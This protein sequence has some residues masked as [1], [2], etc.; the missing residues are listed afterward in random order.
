MKVGLILSGGGEV[1]I[2]WEMGV[3]AASEAKA[4]FLARTCEVIVGTSA[5][6][7][8]GAYVAVGRDLGELVELERAGKGIGSPVAAPVGQRSGESGPAVG[9]TAVVPSEIMA[10]ML[11]T[12]GTVEERG[13]AVGKLAMRAEVAIGP[14]EF[15]NLVKASLGTDAWPPVDFRPTSVNAESGE[16]VQ[17]DRHAGIDFASAVAS[18][19][20]IPGFFPPVPYNGLHYI[21]AQRSSSVRELVSAK[22]LDVV[23]FVGMKSSALANTNEAAELDALADQGL[24]VVKIIGGP[25]IAEVS[26]EL[27]DP[28]ARL[29]AVEIGLEDGHRGAGQLEA[30][31]AS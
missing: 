1:A 4:G 10:A 19:F 30:L 9:G 31:L 29:R 22:A 15:V 5:G 21:D 24:R 3:L 28:V 17:W 11:S 6:A 18:S 12:Q 7:V 14:A 2:A 16:T 23:I 27:M 13:A 26:A 25:S 20:S 8:V